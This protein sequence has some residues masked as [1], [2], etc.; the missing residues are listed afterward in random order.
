MRN[1][2]WCSMGMGNNTL[3]RAWDRLGR[4]GRKIILLFSVSMRQD[5]SHIPIDRRN[6]SDFNTVIDTAA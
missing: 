5:H 2:V 6:H 4:D 3:Q 1:E